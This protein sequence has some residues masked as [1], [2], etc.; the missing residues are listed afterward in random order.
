MRSEGNRAISN[1]SEH[2]IHLRFSHMIDI[3]IFC[4]SDDLIS[5]GEQPESIL[6][7]LRRVNVFLVV[8]WYILFVL[9]TTLAAIQDR[10]D[11][12]RVAF[13]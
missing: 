12:H 7:K 10:I 9:I 1:D 8:S 11:Q 6:N 13:K 3:L 2:K 5:A 4:L